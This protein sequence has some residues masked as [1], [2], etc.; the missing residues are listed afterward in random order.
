MLSAEEQSQVDAQVALSKRLA[1][2]FALSLLPVAG[3]GS[4]A[5][6]VIG[7]RAWKKIEASN[8]K[9]VGGGLATWCVVAG[10]VGLL[11]NALLLWPTI[12][13]F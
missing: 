5:A 8:Q 10:V 11:A 2:G 9:L 1:L 6:I 3:L 13:R 4:L 12:I 7:L